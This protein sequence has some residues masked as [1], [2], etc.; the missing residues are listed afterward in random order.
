M[1]KSKDTGKYKKL[2]KILQ[3]VAFIA[4]LWLAF[5]NLPHQEKILPQVMIYGVAFFIGSFIG[6]AFNWLG[7]KS[8]T[9]KGLVFWLLGGAILSLGGIEVFS[10]FG[11]SEAP[12]WL[13]IYLIGYQFS[14]PTMEM[15]SRDKMIPPSPLP[16][17]NMILW[18]LGIGF[19]LL[20]VCSLLRLVDLTTAWIIWLAVLLP[21]NLYL[22]YNAKKTAAYAQR[23]QESIERSPELMA[24][25][26]QLGDGLEFDSVKCR[27]SFSSQ[28]SVETFQQA[29]PGWMVRLGRER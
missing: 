3:V 22:M 23:R 12:H 8:G 29:A 19:G 5:H 28:A 24:L 9:K 17:E 16:T 11:V 10:F 1:N 26:H 2:G 14:F 27:A 6:L 18:G 4:L 21:G 15:Y 25:F 7:R 13:A 20:L